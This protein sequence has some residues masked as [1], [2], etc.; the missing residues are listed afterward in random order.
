M[1]DLYYIIR[2]WITL[3]AKP[4]LEVERIL[5]EVY[6]SIEN[7]WFESENTSGLLRFEKEVLNQRIY[8]NKIKEK[9]I[10]IY[11]RCKS[12]NIKIITSHCKNYPQ[13]LS[14][15]DNKPYVMYY[16]G[17]LPSEKGIDDSNLIS[18][19][20]SRHCSA[21]GRLIA[22]KF[23][24]ALSRCG[25]GIVSGMARGIDSEAHN[26]SLMANGY[27][28]AV[29]GSGIDKVYP[30]E[31]IRL[32]NKISE[33]GCV[34]SEYFPG[35]PVYKSNFPARNRIISGLSKGILVVEATENS[36]AMITVNTAIN[37]G[38][39]VMAV[40]GNINSENSAGCNLLIRDGAILITS[41]GEILDEFN[42]KYKDNSDFDVW[43]K[44]LSGSEA[45]VVKAIIKGNYTAN[46]I[47][48]FTKR[49]AGN[50]LSTLTM[51]EIKGIVSKGLDGA[52]KVN[53]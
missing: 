46:D 21:Y 12:D 47:S 43:I 5:N 11:D 33:T 1:N 13:N 52:Y 40:P 24:N 17:I 26:G 2:I 22:Y 34:I 42:I 3:L 23:S 35:F 29:L 19:V 27:T 45:D 14:Y 53:K 50:I 31:N 9:A 30:K 37:Q 16:R 44:G 20:G 7:A 51:L 48:V 28:V 38:R 32:Y 6:G 15:V 49:N 18:I 39:T 10:N 8:D 25:L 4:V 36:G 41:Y